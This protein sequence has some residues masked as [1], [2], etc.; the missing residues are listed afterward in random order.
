MPP[1]CLRPAG[2]AHGLPF[3]GLNG[4]PGTPSAQIGRFLAKCSRWAASADS[5]PSVAVGRAQG[6]GA[7]TGSAPVPLA[8]APPGVA[9][10]GDSASAD[11]SMGARSGEGGA[12]GALSGFEGFTGRGAGA[13]LAL[14][15]P[16]PPGAEFAC[17][18]L[19]SAAV[20]CPRL[21]AG[22]GPPRTSLPRP[23][24]PRERLPADLERFG[25]P[26][27]PGRPF[28][29][30]KRRESAAPLSHRSGLALHAVC[31]G[32]LR[33][34][35]AARPAPEF[36]PRHL[37]LARRE[38]RARRPFVA[39]PSPPVSGRSITPPRSAAP[40]PTAAITATVAADLTTAEVASDFAGSG[41]DRPCEA[42]DPACSGGDGGGISA[43]PTC[44]DVP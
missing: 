42:A 37:G 28:L 16:P 21:A 40:T 14:G 33:A 39:L 19:R 17:G 30:P 15:S 6:W 32:L 43:G 25:L 36:Q 13:A 7:S 5:W 23:E 26:A 18:D 44:S 12:T 8:A 24:W 34:R 20:P 29:A 3:V 2:G 31:A 22:G 11:G 41:A 4:S 1:L 27:W 38:T 10:G 35:A 9:V